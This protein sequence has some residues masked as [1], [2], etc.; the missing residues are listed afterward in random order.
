MM[1]VDLASATIST[2]ICEVD[3]SPFKCG[4]L[5]ILAAFLVLFFV[6]PETE[7]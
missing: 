5:T 7:H 6:N 1:T 3:F 2:P 4:H